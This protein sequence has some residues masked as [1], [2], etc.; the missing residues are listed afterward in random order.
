MDFL[1]SNFGFNLSL[2]S[3]DLIVYKILCSKKEQLYLKIIEI[4]NSKTTPQNSKSN[5]KSNISNLI[6]LKKIAETSPNLFYIEFLLVFPNFVNEINKLNK[7]INSNEILVCAYIKL[8]YS[9]KEIARYT[10]SSVR[11]IESKKFRIRKKL[12]LTSNDNLND[13]LIHLE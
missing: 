5:S 11:A 13:F 3:L 4:S 6:E 2:I 10:K 8:N 12:K 9:T 7:S 1:N